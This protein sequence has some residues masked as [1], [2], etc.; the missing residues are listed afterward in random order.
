MVRVYAKVR[1]AAMVA[2]GGLVVAAFLSSHDPEFPFA[3][4]WI[5]AVFH[6]Q[7]QQ[8]ATVAPA[9]A[10]AAPGPRAYSPPPVPPRIS[11]D[12]ATPKQ[13]ARRIPPR[14]KPMTPGALASTVLHL[15]PFSVETRYLS[16]AGYLRYLFHQKTGRWISLAEAA[17]TLA[18]PRR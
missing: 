6:P 15:K 9:P 16:Y 4:A 3:S 12:T 14:R 17:E 8:R 7:P 1:A 10:A 5:A 2:A 13:R 11:A 18:V